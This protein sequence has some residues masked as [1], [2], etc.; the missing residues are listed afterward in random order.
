MGKRGMPG[1]EQT[2]D[3]RKTLTHTAPPP[4]GSAHPAGRRPL[5]SI[6]LTLAAELPWRGA[7]P[8]LRGDRDG[9]GRA[10]TEG[11]ERRAGTTRRRLIA[12]ASRQFADRPYSMV[13]LDDILAE[14]ELTK[15]AMY[16]H[17]PSK[18]AL[19]LAI[20]DDLTEMSRAVVTELLARKM[21]GLETLIDLVY[22]LVVQDTQHDVARA[23]VRLLETLHTTTALPPV[24]QTWIE[25][26]T[27]LIQKAVTEGDVID[28]HDPEDIA[29]MLVALW[30]GTRRISEPDQPERYLDNLQKAWILALPGFTNPDRID[31][32]TQFIK[33]HHA[34]AV[35]KVSAEA[36]SLDPHTTAA[37]SAHTDP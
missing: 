21:S 11:S 35:K 36:L 4:G 23:G 27:T 17:F 10:L 20:I 26:V 1:G 24:W 32:F 7:I 29:K 3:H 5:S 14:A 22:L 30:A 15:G 25:F 33:R 18:E 19:A 8:P 9:T 37:A 6:G 34:L 13:S 12:A 16:F 2:A 31:Y 28:R